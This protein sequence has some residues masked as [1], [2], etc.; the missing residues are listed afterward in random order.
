MISFAVLPLG[1]LTPLAVLGGFIVFG[2]LVALFGPS[3]RRNEA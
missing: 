1:Q 3:R 2:L